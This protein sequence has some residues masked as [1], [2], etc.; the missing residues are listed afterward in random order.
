VVHSHATAFS[1]ENLM[2]LALYLVGVSES[3]NYWR[4]ANLTCYPLPQSADIRE[5]HL[6]HSGKVSTSSWQP[7][8]VVCSRSPFSK[9]FD[10]CHSILLQFPLI[11]PI[12]IWSNDLPDPKKLVSGKRAYPCTYLGA[13]TSNQSDRRRVAKRASHMRVQ[14]GNQ[15]FRFLY[16]SYSEDP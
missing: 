2:L 8:S 4:M 10:A 14:H 15:R 7:S 1:L 12:A 3:H 5:R 11:P 9:P 16:V 6:V 13:K